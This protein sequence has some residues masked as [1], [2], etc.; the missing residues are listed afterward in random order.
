MINKKTVQIKTMVL[1]LLEP[2]N[3]RTVSSRKEGTDQ[4]SLSIEMTEILVSLWFVI[5]CPQVTLYLT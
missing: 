3:V 4:R 1:L 2:A 5:N